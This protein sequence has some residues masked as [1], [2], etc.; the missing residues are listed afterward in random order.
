MRGT[1]FFKIDPLTGNIYDNYLHEFDEN[2][3]S[4]LAEL[5]EPKLQDEELIEYVITDMVLRNNGKLIIIAEQMFEQTYN[6][7]NNLIVMCYDTNGQIYWSR[8]IDKR[9][10]YNIY[11]LPAEV[12]DLEDYRDFIMQTGALDQLFDKNYCSYAL[13]A[14]LDESGIIL[15]YNDDIRNLDETGKKRSFKR[16]KKS[17]IL[18]VAIDEFGNISKTPVVE[19]KKKMLFPEPMRFYDNLYNTIVIPA[20][21]YR[22]YNYYKITAGF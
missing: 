9:Q 21:R 14:P 1:F 16:P 12:V 3:L 8:V 22:N 20:F 5:E 11:N 2:L 10:N 7:Y 13:M 15:F 17:Y 18:A 4:Q 6:T 19:W